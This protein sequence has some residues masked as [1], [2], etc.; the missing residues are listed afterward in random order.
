M[1]VCVCVYVYVCNTSEPNV[2]VIAQ[3]RSDALKDSP[4]LVVF[5]LACSYIADTKTYD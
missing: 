4:V 3:S 1:Y 5:G 2:D